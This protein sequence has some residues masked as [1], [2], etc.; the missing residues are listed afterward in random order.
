MNDNV[1]DIYGNKEC[2]ICGTRYGKACEN[3]CEHE[4]ELGYE[5]DC[6]ITITCRKCLK[7]F[8]VDEFNDDFI[9]TRRS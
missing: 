8:T 5:Y 7:E 4:I 3:C 6:G 9:I 2:S 1:I